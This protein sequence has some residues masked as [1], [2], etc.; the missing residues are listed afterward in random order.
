MRNG[1]PRNSVR[2][3]ESERISNRTHL[4]D[5][6]PRQKQP[7]RRVAI[8]RSHLNVDASNLREARLFSEISKTDGHPSW[9]HVF[10]LT[11][12]LCGKRCAE[13]QSSFLQRRSS[14]C[15]SRKPSAWC[16][17]TR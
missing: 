2:E 9:I 6:T 8:M 17:G 14:S 4:T 16:F 12:K 11:P 10:P 1:R 13:P 7:R 15:E 3:A 5:A